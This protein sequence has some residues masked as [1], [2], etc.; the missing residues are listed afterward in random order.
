MTRAPGPT[1]AV[2]AHFDPGGHVAPHVRRYLRLLAEAVDRVVIVS[3]AELD[4]TGRAELRR[5]G[6]L[7]ERENIGYDFYSWKTGLDHAGDWDSYSRVVICNDSVVGPT[8]PLAEVLGRNAPADADFW[9]MTASHEISPH[10][11]SWFVVF[12]RPVIASGLLHGFWGAMEPVSNRYVVIRRYEVGLSRLLLTGGLRMGSYLRLSPKAALRAEFRHRVALQKVPKATEAALRPA[13]SLLEEL[14]APFR[15]PRWNPTYVMWDAV[16]DGR[17]PF[18]KMEVLRDDPYEI[19]RERMLDQ[20][21]TAFPAEFE[22]V[23]EYLDRTREDFRR[24]R[25]LHPV[26]PLRGLPQGAGTQPKQPPSD[27]V[28]RASGADVSLGGS[29][30]DNDDG[31]RLNPGATV[32]VTGQG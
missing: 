6:E 3:T 22:G 27:G 29:S 2:F 8:R 26:D 19:G 11:Q 28:E 32:P 15:A 25:G 18:V 16:F 21:E 31:D 13:G 23:R 1:L 14:R 5:H 17:L 24:L 30:D 20:L 9:G 10:V 4:D 7:V 12:E